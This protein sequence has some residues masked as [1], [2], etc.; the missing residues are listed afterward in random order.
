M[1]QIEDFV[2]GSMK[3]YLVGLLIVLGIGVGIFV[4]TPSPPDSVV[5]LDNT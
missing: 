4:F 5:L 3:K 2:E 1:F